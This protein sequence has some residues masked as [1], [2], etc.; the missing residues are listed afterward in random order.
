M[1]KISF[2][3]KVLGVIFLAFLITIFITYNYFNSTFLTFENDYPEKLEF[4]KLEEDGYTFLDRNSNGKLD[5]YED[6]RLS[7]DV[8]VEDVLSQMTLQE[9]I[10]LLKGSGISSAI[11]ITNPEGVK[12]AVGTIVATPRLGLPTLYLSDG[13]AGLRID[14]EREDE[15]RKYYSTAFPI[16]TQLASTWNENLLY[17]IG[18]AMGEEAIDYGVDLILGPGV[19]IHRHPLCGR[20]FEY[21]SE[22]PLLSGYI[23]A[24][25]INGIESNGVGATLKH[26]VAN[27]QETNRKFNDVIVS[28]RA[29][30]EIYLKGFEYIIKRSQPWAV[31]SSYNKIGGTYTSESKKLLH[32]ILREDWRFQG[33]VMTD[34]FGGENPAKQIMSGNDLIEPGTKIQWEELISAHASGLLDEYSINLAASR[35]LTVIFKSKKMQSYK[36]SNNPDLKNNADLARYGA[37]EGIVLLKNDMV[38]P[39]SDKQNIAL[40]GVPSYDLISGGTG[41][42]DV[43][44]AYTVSIEE[45][46]I[47]AGYQINKTASE[48]FK[49]HKN[50]NSE[51]FIRPVGMESIFTD[52]SPPQINYTKKQLQEIVKTADIGLF[53]LSRNSGEF[54]DR[55]F[56]GDF[57]LTQEELQRISLISEVFNSVNKK[58]IIILNIGGVI[59][60]KSWKS[61]PDAILLSWQGGQEGGNAIADVLSGKINPSGKL[62]MT[63]PNKLSDHASDANFP[64]N[65]IEIELQDMFVGMMFPPEER[66]EEDKIRDEDYTYYEEG[67]Y[68][69][70]RHFDKRSFDVSYPFGYGLS[71]T[72]FQFENGKVL[73]ENDSIKVSTSVINT[74]SVP[75]K[76]VIQ[77]Y[78][79]KKNSSIDRPIRE[80]KGFAKTKLLEVNEKEDIVI[81]IAIKDLRYWSESIE[82]WTLEQG[83]YIINIGNSSRDI[84]QEIEIKL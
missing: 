46:L 9:K 26:F 53:T 64:D 35:I 59:E 14:P 77:V 2:T 55:Y 82:Q 40:L 67:V 11:G 44:E 63:F 5:P 21:Y 69:G 23:G 12:G 71:Y 65:R 74:G 81:S 1:K 49:E 83:S 79:Q 66:S 52:Y 27:N 17:Q 15:N 57:L 58:V 33:M 13:P 84:L 51:S 19:N 22:D 6:N 80:L 3:L 16:A 54:T 24:A 48:I 72:N 10:H 75:G 32:D 31:M 4:N 42:G 34:W 29:L 47:N 18:D 37:S 30:R 76:E 41:S 50:N 60:T 7:I 20:N 25:F 45:G 68:V 61:Y 39:L 8:R 28:E 38:L 43:N 70:Y 73:V 36:R 62:P 56:E 78:T